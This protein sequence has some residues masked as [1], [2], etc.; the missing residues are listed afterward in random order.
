VATAEPDERTEKRIGREGSH[1]LQAGLVGTT[2][3]GV[4]VATFGPLF[5]LT[6]AYVL[7]SGAA[8]TAILGLRWADR[9]FHRG[10]STLRRARHDAQIGRVLS[11]TTI[12]FVLY[13]TGL[14]TLLLVTWPIVLFVTLLAWSVHRSRVVPATLPRDV[15]A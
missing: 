11:V 10:H 9:V 15:E 8:V 12:L 4:T 3:V 7:L 13:Y 6:F 2:L 1:A 14:W 5:D